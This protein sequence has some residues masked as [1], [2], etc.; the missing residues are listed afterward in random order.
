MEE[1]KAFTANELVIVKPL[2]MDL[3]GSTGAA[4]RNVIPIDSTSFQPLGSNIQHILDDIEPEVDLENFLGTEHKRTKRPILEMVE[5]STL[6][7]MA[8]EEHRT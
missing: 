4:S 6:S 3:L 8:E 7:P 1:L 2:N 5:S